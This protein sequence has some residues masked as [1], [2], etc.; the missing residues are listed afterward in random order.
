VR[1]PGWTVSGGGF[2]QLLGVLVLE[3]RRAQIS[4]R[5]VE[6]TVL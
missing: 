2:D 4:E 1:P 6:T 5:G 3:L